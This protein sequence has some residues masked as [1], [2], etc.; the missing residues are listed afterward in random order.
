MKQTAAFVLVIWLFMNLM[1]WM[2]RSMPDYQTRQID[3][4]VRYMDILFPLSRLSC[5]IGDQ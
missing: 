2:I 5:P 3:C 4:K 1:L